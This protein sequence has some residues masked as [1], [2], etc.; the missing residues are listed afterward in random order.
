MDRENAKLARYMRLNVWLTAAV[1]AALCLALVLVVPR[2]TAAVDRLTGTL[3][4]LDAVLS[5]VNDL[6]DKA[7]DTLAAATQALESATEAADNANRLVED[8]SDAVAE[9]MEKFNSV[10]FEALNRA[11]NDLADIVEPLAKVANLFN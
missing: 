8:N 2:V 10:D 6:S 5:E 4:R 9:A 11:I 7:D 1:L 3:S